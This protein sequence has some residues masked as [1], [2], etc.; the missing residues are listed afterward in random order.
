MTI[1]RG[2]VV[3]ENGQ[4]HAGLATASSCSARSPT[5]SA[6]ALLFEPGSG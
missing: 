3:V 5:K 6:P 4:F 2:K 1:L